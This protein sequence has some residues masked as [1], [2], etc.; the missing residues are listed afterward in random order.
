MKSAALALI[1]LLVARKWIR[2]DP[3]H[4]GKCLLHPKERFQVPVNGKVRL[5]SQGILQDLLT[6][7]NCHS[8]SSYKSQLH[9]ITN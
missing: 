4:L 8:Y 3:F 5:S 6:E 1:V 2:Q 9:F 7:D